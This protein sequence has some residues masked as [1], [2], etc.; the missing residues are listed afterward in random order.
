MTL[1]VEFHVPEKYAGKKVDYYVYNS[2]SKGDQ[3]ALD[4]VPARIDSIPV[5][6]KNKWLKHVEK[7]TVI[8]PDREGRVKCKPARTGNVIDIMYPESAKGKQ[9]PR[10]ISV[11]FRTS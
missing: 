10:H 3:K 1:G 2:L 11:E 8:V 7:K 5:R 6:S 4:Y 9:G